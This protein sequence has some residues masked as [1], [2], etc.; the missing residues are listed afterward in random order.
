MPHF[1]AL[2]GQAGSLRCA[3]G[4]GSAT[5]NSLP[6]TRALQYMDEAARRGNVPGRPSRIVAGTHA[7]LHQPSR[8][9][10]DWTRRARAATCRAQGA[11]PTASRCFGVK[12][13]KRARIHHQAVRI[14]FTVDH[15]SVPRCN[16]FGEP[17]LARPRPTESLLLI[18]PRRTMA[19][20][21]VN[22]V[23]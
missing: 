12:C 14:Q 9:S 3:D 19:P 1:A 20:K 13:R 8:P 18:S 16:F 23:A 4:D 21:L 6:N 5:A 11:Q 7:H 2:N 10:R 17:N 22:L 15:V